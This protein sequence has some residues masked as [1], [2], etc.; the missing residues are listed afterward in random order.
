[1]RDEMSPFGVLGRD[2]RAFGRIVRLAVGLLT[3][4]SL[5]TSIGDGDLPS[6][7]VPLALAGFLTMAA[8]YV[9]LHRALGE[10]VLG[11][12]HPWVA[13]AITLAPLGV[14][15]QL[16]AVPLPFRTGITFYIGVSLIATA[17][18]AYGGCEVV[19]I[20]T[21]LFRRRYIVYCPFNA[22]DL[23]ER[24]TR[25]GGPGWLRTAAGVIALPSLAY[26]LFLSDV[27]DDLGIH[28]PGTHPYAAVLL[29]A[30]ALLGASAVW[31]W[32]KAYHFTP[33]V[34]N[35]LIG[36]AILIV[37]TLIFEDVVASNLVFAAVSLGAL[38]TLLARATWRRWK[39]YQATRGHADR[40]PSDRA[41]G[42]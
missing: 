1:M 41:L 20:P 42:P 24:P 15:R 35:D 29:L 8:F 14:V 7:E 28:G 30:A 19:A 17:A 31:A 11:R 9:A 38:V 39:Q 4:A 3:L 27:L 6:R 2:A 16:P 26:F 32:A 37:L 18:I 12:I 22:L 40:R 33:N 13:T 36:A 25:F 21:L 34:R 5:V 23:V 10:R